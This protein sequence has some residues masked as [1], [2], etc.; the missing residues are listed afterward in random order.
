MKKSI[1]GI[2]LGII[3]NQILQYSVYNN[4]HVSCLYSLTIPIISNIYFISFITYFLYI[5]KI[6]LYFLL[7][8]LV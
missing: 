8:T 5:R 7:N 2:S 1:V 4:K 6:Q 3:K